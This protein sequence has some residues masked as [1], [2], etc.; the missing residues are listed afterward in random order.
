MSIGNNQR[1]FVRD[2]KPFFYLADTCWSAFTNISEEEWEYYL[3]YRRQQGFNVLQINILP[4]WDACATPYNCYP[5]PTKDSVRFE[6]TKWND[7]YFEHARR[8]CEKAIKKGF[9][10]ALVVLWCNY[11]PGTWASAKMPE[12]IIPYEFLDSYLQRVH[13]TFSALEPI[14][15]ISGD[16]DFTEESNRYYRKALDYL[17]AR[18]HKSLYTF[19]IKGRYTE[20][21][22]EFRN[23]VD[24]YMYQSGHNAQP[25]NIKMPYYL[26]EEFYKFTPKRPVMNAEP[27]YEQMGFSR[28]MYGRFWQSDIRKAA[29]QS[30]LSGA[31]AGIAYGAAG[32]YGWEKTGYRAPVS[33]EGFDTPNPWNLA[34][35]YP[36]AW[37]YGYISYLMKLYGFV[38]LIPKQELLATEKEGMRCAVCKE[39]G[40]IVIYV[41]FNTTVRLKGDFT[42]KEIHMIDMR[43]KNVCVYCETVYENGITK[44]GLHMFE[45]DALLIIKE[46][47]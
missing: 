13:E 43:E 10:P 23:K 22:E 6:F 17:Q 24:F 25:E 9:I 14:Y 42:D 12:N 27:C 35:H 20:L 28:N 29:W 18:N 21:P 11:V 46:K 37:D 15:I 31:G 30:I 34:L 39:A 26:A 1:N 32:I 47:L 41:P 2:G 44:I 3:T 5:L 36:G 45:G 4:Q 16:S 19:H 40:C 7:E 33:S 38:S 8:M